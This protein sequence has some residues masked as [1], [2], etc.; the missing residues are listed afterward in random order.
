[1]FDW[2]YLD[3]YIVL[4][5]IAFIHGWYVGRSEGVA[6][7]SAA[8]FDHMYDQATPV[9]EKKNTRTLEITLDD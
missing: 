3:W 2:V 6:K 7:G 1:M 9:P 4:L 5:P 8:M